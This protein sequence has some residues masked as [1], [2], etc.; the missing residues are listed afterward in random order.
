MPAQ[1]SRTT[2]AYGESSDFQTRGAVSFSCVRS[3]AR[4]PEPPPPGGRC[5]RPCQLDR[6]DSIAISSV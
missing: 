5:G 1:I 3:E 4:A 6:P 2:G